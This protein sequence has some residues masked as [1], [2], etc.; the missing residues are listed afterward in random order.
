[1]EWIACILAICMLGSFADFF[2]LSADFQ[3]KKYNKNTGSIRLLIWIVV[4]PL[5]YKIFVLTELTEHD[6]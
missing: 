5:G 4:N 3:K 2:L 6:G 1:M